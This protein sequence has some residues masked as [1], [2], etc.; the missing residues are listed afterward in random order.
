MNSLVQ[1]TEKLVQI[2]L[3]NSVKEFIHFYH[4]KFRDKANLRVS[5]PP[6]GIHSLHPSLLVGS[7]L[8]LFPF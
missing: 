5:L 8:K 2:S 6:S 7:I 3:S 1:E 4:L